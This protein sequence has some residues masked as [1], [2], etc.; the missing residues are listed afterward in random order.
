VE[1]SLSA[2]R[3]RP[4]SHVGRNARARRR[5]RLRPPLPRLPLGMAGQRDP[6]RPPSP[7][8]PVDRPRPPRRGEAGRPCRTWR[9]NSKTPSPARTSRAPSSAARTPQA[10]PS[11]RA[12]RLQPRPA[13]RGPILARNLRFGPYPRRRQAVR[14]GLQGRPASPGQRRI[15]LPRRRRL[16]RSRLT[17]RR[18]PDQPR[19]RRLQPRQPAR[20]PRA[21]PKLPRNRPPNR[22]GRTRSQLKISRRNS[23]G[24]SAV[25]SIARTENPDRSLRTASPGLKERRPSAL[26]TRPGD[27]RVAGLGG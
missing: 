19:P 24:C 18:R 22:H 5:S 25:R 23:R 7:G 12:L 20:S 17:G 2:R 21:G 16:P 15:R 9:A 3:P 26:R 6:L 27:P 4:A 8:W 14:Q 13:W 11:V 1:N 10:L